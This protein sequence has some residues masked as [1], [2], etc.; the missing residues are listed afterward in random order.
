MSS[1]SNNLHKFINQH[2]INSLH[3]EIQIYMNPSI[4]LMT[5]NLPLLQTPI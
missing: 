2:T 4:G 1:N 3:M 5:I